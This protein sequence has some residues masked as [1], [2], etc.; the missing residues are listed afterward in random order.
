MTRAE[1]IKHFEPYL[2]N[3]CYTDKHRQAIQMAIAALREQEER[4]NPHQLTVDELRRVKNN[5]PIL[6]YT[7]CLDEDGS[8]LTDCGEWNMF[9]GHAFI[10]DGVYGTLENYG[11]TFIAFSGKPD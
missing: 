1:A 7:V 3:E 5:S 8:L 9:D 10:G 6:V 4:A 2:D 11:K